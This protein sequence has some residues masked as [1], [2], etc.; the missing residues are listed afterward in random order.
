M[1]SENIRN[2]RKRLGL[3]MAEFG[4]HIGVSIDVVKNMEY[5]KASHNKILIDHMCAVYNINPEYLETGEGDM[6]IQKSPLEAALD[7]H[8]LTEDQKELI[9]GVLELPPDLQ[10]A[11]LKIMHNVKNEQEAPKPAEPETIRMRV[12]PIL[13]I[14]A[15]LDGSAE[16]KMAALADEKETEKQTTLTE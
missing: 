16:A 15:K 7:S 9:R 4:R 8:N 3:T 2:V 6:F 1:L 11:F 5:G 13:P 10:K 12:T 14:V